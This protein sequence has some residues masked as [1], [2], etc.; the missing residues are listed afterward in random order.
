MTKGESPNGGFRD[1]A[2][3]GP[4]GSLKFDL[5]ERTAQFGEN[6]IALLKG[7]PET[8]ITGRIIDQLMASAGSVGA[9]YAEADDG[10]TRKDFR[11]KIGLCR[12]ES[13]ESKHWLRLLAAAH[14]PSRD[15]ARVLWR[16]AKELNLIFSHIFKKCSDE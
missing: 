1:D 4:S 10:V 7:V 15:A 9:N 13:R 8:K 5:E 14:P 6:V 2:A 12:K 16:E 3:P 11:H